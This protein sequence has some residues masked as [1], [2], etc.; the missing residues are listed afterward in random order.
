MNNPDNNPD[1]APKSPADPGDS[2]TYSNAIQPG[3]KG[4]LRYFRLNRRLP[5]LRSISPLSTTWSAI[6]YSLVVIAVVA[7]SSS[8][9]EKTLYDKYIIYLEGA[10]LPVSDHK[11]SA[12]FYRDVLDLVEQDPAPAGDSPEQQ[13]S[14]FLITPKKRLFLQSNLPGQGIDRSPVLIVR[15]RNGF[16]KLHAELIKRTKFPVQTVET[17]NALEQVKASHVTQIFRSSRGDEFLVS[18]PDHNRI[19]FYQP[20]RKLL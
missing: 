1:I 2:T 10:I 19:I 12:D 18:D 20:V 3:K 4:F 5:S 14:T 16:K 6:W 7:R 9:V 15:V 8:T 17:E 13:Q 11:N